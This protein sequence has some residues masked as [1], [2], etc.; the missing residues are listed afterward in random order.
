MKAVGWL[1]ALVLASACSTE[2][3]SSAS[4][5]DDDDG[6]NGTFTAFVIDLIENHTNETEEP[7]AFEMFASLPDPDVDNLDAY[8]ALF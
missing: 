7:V 1:F 6:M 2:G 4:T 5:E 8:V 3:S